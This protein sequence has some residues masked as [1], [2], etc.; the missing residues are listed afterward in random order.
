MAI[1][2][3]IAMV[4]KNRSCLVA[5]ILRILREQISKELGLI[6]IFFWDYFLKT[7]PTLVLTPV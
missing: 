6:G 5:V 3:N 2:R 1:L 4:S 7:E